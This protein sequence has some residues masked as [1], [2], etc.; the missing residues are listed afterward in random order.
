MSSNRSSRWVAVARYILVLPA[1]ITITL[2]MM[3]SIHAQQNIKG[4]L[5]VKVIPMGAG[6]DTCWKGSGTNSPGVAGCHQEFK[7]SGGIGRTFAETCES[8][9]ILI[10]HTPGHSQGACPAGY[11]QHDG[12][13]GKPSRIDCNAFCGGAKGKSDRGSCARVAAPAPCGGQSAICRCN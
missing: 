8:G 13:I 4:S 3:F 11:H 1:V 2:L 6:Q 10:D 12:D 9:T 7:K 5:G